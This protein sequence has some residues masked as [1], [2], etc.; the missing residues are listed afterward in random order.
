MTDLCLTPPAF[1]AKE[2]SSYSKHLVL[3]IQEI[4]H[5]NFKLLGNS[6]LM[7]ANSSKNSNA[8]TED[9]S[10]C[11]TLHRA[12]TNWLEEGVIFVFLCNGRA[13]G[14]PFMQITQAAFS[15]GGQPFS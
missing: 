14:F 12:I 10:P 8:Q 13:Q 6:L 4:E 7:W 9:N 5:K 11:P 15:K 2:R 1:Q 3:G